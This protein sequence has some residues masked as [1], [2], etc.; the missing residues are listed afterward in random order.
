MHFPELCLGQP[1]DFAH[2]TTM[3]TETSSKVA[4]HAS[5]REGEA[6][7]V[8]WNGFLWLILLELCLAFPYAALGV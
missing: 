2:L 5:W 4:A 8:P 1:H 6:A 7:E 3:Q